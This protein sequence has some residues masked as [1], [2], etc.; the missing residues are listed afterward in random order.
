[1][2]RYGWLS[3]LAM[4]V[5]LLAGCA[6]TQPPESKDTV[7]S[8]AQEESAVQGVSGYEEQDGKTGL[9]GQVVLKDGGTQLA[10]AFVNIYPDTTSNLLGPSLFISSPTDAEG[11]YQIEVP[12]GIYYVVA[13]K[14]TTGEPSGPLAPGDY[15]SE[16]KRIKAEV[17][18]G[19]MARVDLEVVPMKAPMFFKKNLVERKTDTGIRG[20]LLDAAGNPVPGSFAIA[21]VD[22]N[23]KRLPDYASTLSDSQG[24]FTIYLPKGGT[25]YL[26]ARVHAWDMPLHG[27]LYGKLGGEQPTPLQVLKGRFLEDVDLVLTPFSG[28]Y[29]PG[30]SRRPY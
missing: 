30:K 23:L 10:G 18:D 12:A 13:R 25:Y 27:E 3:M 14:R 29:K 4:V 9:V 5:F 11:R 21:Y 24:R 20:R 22:A 2:K 1:M 7:G 16:H 28:E 15:Y 6:A 19:S 26:A 8:A 17:R